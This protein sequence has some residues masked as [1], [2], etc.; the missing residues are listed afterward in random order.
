MWILFCL[1]DYE[2]MVVSSFSI[3][4]SGNTNP[5]ESTLIATSKGVSFVPRRAAYRRAHDSSKL[6]SIAELPHGRWRL[7]MHFVPAFGLS[8]QLSTLAVGS[9]KRINF[10]AFRPSRLR[11]CKRAAASGDKPDKKPW[12]GTRFVLIRVDSCFIDYWEVEKIDGSRYVNLFRD[13]TTNP[14]L[15]N[16]DIL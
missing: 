9:C 12:I 1:P 7:R 16:K 14:I 8:L 11:G 6:S 10:Q 13:S 15:L 2:V 4:N 3:I 5:R